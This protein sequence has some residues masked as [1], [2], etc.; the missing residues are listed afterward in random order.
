MSEVRVKEYIEQPPRVY[1]IQWKQENQKE[2][3]EELRNKFSKIK[4]ISANTTYPDTGRTELAITV[5]IYEPTKIALQEGDYI[6]SPGFHYGEDFF[7]LNEEVFNK[8]YK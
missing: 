4:E 6:C 7:T 2:V 3:I 1:A 8:K 5:G